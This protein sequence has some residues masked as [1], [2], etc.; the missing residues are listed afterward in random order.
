VF[1]AIEKRAKEPLIPMRIFKVRNLLPSNIVMALLGAAWI[2]MWFFLNLYL[3]QVQGYGPFESGLALLPMTG[4]IMAMMIGLTPRLLSK[5]SAKRSMVAGLALLSLAMA[6]FAVMP[7]GGSSFAV[8][9]LPASLIAAAGMSLAYVPV[10]TTA[11][12]H[13][14][15]QEMGLA[16]G[17]VSTAYQIG[18]ALGLAI[19]VSAISFVAAQAQDIGTESVQALNSGFELAFMVVAIVAASSAVMAAVAVKKSDISDKNEAP[20]AAA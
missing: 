10:L 15:G 19:V 8:Y 2:P 9:G 7:S 20:M 12:S 17:I 6:L 13:A 4:A 14:K 1:A 11:V 5:I 18:S 3:Q 16:S